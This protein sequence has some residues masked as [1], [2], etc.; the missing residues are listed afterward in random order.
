MAGYILCLYDFKMAALVGMVVLGYS[1]SISISIIIS[2]SREEATKLTFSTELT[3]YFNSFL[4]IEIHIY[5]EIR[6]F[7]GFCPV[8][9]YILYIYTYLIQLSN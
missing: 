2:I 8:Y 7:G 6:Q 9:T 5:I 1:F 4:E 3:F